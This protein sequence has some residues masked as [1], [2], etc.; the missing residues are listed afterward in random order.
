MAVSS[1]NMAS[2]TLGSGLDGHLALPPSKIASVVEMFAGRFYCVSGP[3]A[4][5]CS[6]SSSSMNTASSTLGRGLDD[7]LA[8][9]PSKIVSVVVMYAGKVLLSV[10]ATCQW[11][12]VVEM[13]LLLHSEAVG[14]ITL[15][16]LLVK[17]RVSW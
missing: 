9:P 8:L 7:H 11:L 6:S 2:S 17:L 13:R 14:M 10:W 5:G 12:L 1:R 3:P 15:P 4:I 16:F